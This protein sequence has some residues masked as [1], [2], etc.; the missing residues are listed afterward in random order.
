LASFG[1]T[2]VCA[3]A[4][5]DLLRRNAADCKL[6]FNL[7]VV[8]SYLTGL[9]E[10]LGG[11]SAARRR[12]ELTD[13][14]AIIAPLLGHS[15]QPFYRLPYG[16]DDARVATD[17]APAGYLRKVGW[18][19]DSWGWRGVPAGDIVARCLQLAAP[20][21]VYVFH[22]GRAS[23]D[24]LALDQVIQGLRERGFGFRRI[25]VG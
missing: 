15:T 4:N 7:S 12:A 6:V 19:I 9:S 25:D 14:D 23:Q 3:R 2:G 8:H 20:N 17:V 18:T 5:P 13:A 24:A 10:N 11:L 16:D 21:A 22:V 1:I